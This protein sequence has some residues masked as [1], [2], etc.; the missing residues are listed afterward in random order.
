MS[1]FSVKNKI[2]VRHVFCIEIWT[3]FARL[4]PAV[5]RR[6]CGSLTVDLDKGSRLLIWSFTPT[7]ALWF[8]FNF[9]SIWRALFCQQLFFIKSVNPSFFSKKLYNIRGS[10]ETLF[11]SKL[12]IYQLDKNDRSLRLFLVEKVRKTPIRIGECENLTTMGPLFCVP[13]FCKGSPYFECY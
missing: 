7:C 8:R 9:D 4:T 2:W 10:T 13:L 5:N 6:I 1:H 3:S 12:I 11:K